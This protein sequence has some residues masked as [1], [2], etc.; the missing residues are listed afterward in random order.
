MKQALTPFQKRQ[1]LFFYHKA[2]RPL[3]ALSPAAAPYH[4]VSGKPRYLLF[5]KRRHIALQKVPFYTLKGHLLEAKRWPFASVLIV[6]LLLTNIHFCQTR[7]Q[8]CRIYDYIHT[9]A[10]P[11]P[12]CCNVEY[13]GYLTMTFCVD[14]LP[15]VYVTTRMLI[16]LTIPLVS[17]PDTS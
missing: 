9:S 2:L 17:R 14:V 11:G 3:L 12:A 10:R 6:S 1:G 16:P 8:I 15:S 5:S 13:C 4:A 7:R